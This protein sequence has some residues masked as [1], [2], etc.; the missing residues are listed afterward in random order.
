[1]GGSSIFKDEEKLSPNYVPKKLVDREE[2][3]RTLVRW[4]KPVLEGGA[5]QKVTIIGPRGSGKTVLSLLFCRELQSY[6]KGQKVTFSYSHVNCRKQST[7]WQMLGSLLRSCAPGESHKGLGESEV[8][9]L[10]EKATVGGKT[11]RVFVFDNLGA[12]VRRDDPGFLYYITR[13]REDG[14]GSGKLSL[15]ISLEKEKVLERLDEATRS[16]LLHNYLRLDGYGRR[17]IFKILE[18]RKKAAFKPRAVGEG[19]LDVISD[20]VSSSGDAGYA[21][22]ALQKSGEVCERKGGETILPNHAREAIRWL[23]EGIRREDLEV[24]HSHELLVLRALAEFLLSSG[25]TPPL[26]GQLFRSYKRL[27]ESKGKNAR[28]YSSFWRYVKNL[29]EEGLVEAKVSRGGHRGGSR[30]I[31]LSKADPRKVVENLAS[32]L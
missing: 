19:V 29:L 13:I 9:D 20:R 14:V 6:E 30:E 5:N 21:L 10:I 28:C 7:S 18:E 16:T 8:L 22:A 24:L 27:C 12:I 26:M 11:R 4:F 1:M 31:T 3:M 15:I 25:G 32:W 17:Q 23:D 2:E